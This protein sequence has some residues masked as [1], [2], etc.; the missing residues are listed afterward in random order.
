MSVKLDWQYSNSFQHFLLL[1]N[2]P[3]AQ[4]NSILLH[5]LLVQIKPKYK[6]LNNAQFKKIV[7]FRSVEK[8]I[9]SMRLYWAGSTNGS[10]H[11]PIANCGLKRMR[12]FS[13]R[14]ELHPAPCALVELQ[15]LSTC[16]CRPT[17]GHN[18]RR[19]IGTTT[20]IY[21]RLSWCSHFCSCLK[22]FVDEEI[23]CYIK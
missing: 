11:W 13:A 14:L 3:I 4:I 20:F 15:M 18:L 22:C 16:F 7:T 12:R 23:M 19:P 9:F 10:T 21:F 1:I 6:G 5:L 8:L 2:V 17:D